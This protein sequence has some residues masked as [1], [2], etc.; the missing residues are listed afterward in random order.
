MIDEVARKRISTDRQRID[1]LTNI[2]NKLVLEVSSL[3]SE[4]NELR[5]QLERPAKITKTK[6][7]QAERDEL[8]EPSEPEKEE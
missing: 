4:V 2:V 8:I 7:K 5:A 3:T 6:V 1:N